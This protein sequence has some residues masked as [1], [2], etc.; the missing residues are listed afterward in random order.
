MKLK[1]FTGIFR[2]FKYS[3]LWLIVTVVVFSIAVWWQNLS[4]IFNV[5]KSPHIPLISKISIPLSFL[6]SISTNFTL[7]AEIYV[8]LISILFGLSVAIT[9]Y[10]LDRRFREIKN[11]GITLGLIGII[12][13]LFSLGCAACGPLLITT[14]L[15]LV[16]AS[17]ILAFLPLKGQEFGIIGVI[18]LVLSIYLTVKQI[19]D[20][21]V[22]RLKRK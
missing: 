8:I 2:K 18:L 20:P 21:T 22:C 11:H 13:S 4:V 15:S 10:Y 14:L 3:A 9:V 6:G 17:S 5:I 1:T 7:E 12:A 16:G 19:E